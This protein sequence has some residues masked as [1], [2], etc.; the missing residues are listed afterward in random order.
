MKGAGPSFPKTLPKTAEE[1]PGVTNHVIPGLSVERS[2]PPSEGVGQP[3]PPTLRMG[4]LGFV[5]GVV[6]EKI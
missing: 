1:S 4:P 3:P 2:P 5:Y 6:L